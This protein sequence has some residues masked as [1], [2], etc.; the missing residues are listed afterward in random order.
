VVRI[1]IDLPLNRGEDHYDVILALNKPLPIFLLITL[2]SNCKNYCCIDS[3]EAS[4]SSTFKTASPCLVM[5]QKG[6][7]HQP[8]AHYRTGSAENYK[9]IG[10]FNGNGNN[11]KSIHQSLK[12]SS[13]VVMS[14][15][16]TVMDPRQPLMKCVYP[17]GRYDTPASS[18]TVC[19]ECGHILINHHSAPY[20][21]AFDSYSSH[22]LLLGKNIC[23]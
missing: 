6:T 21:V 15:P 17:A 1:I 5:L 10:L 7:S 8:Y 4:V 9:P 18:D 22:K 12:T 19:R 14:G 11:L 16:C 3:F 23:F 13:R 20:H 2:F